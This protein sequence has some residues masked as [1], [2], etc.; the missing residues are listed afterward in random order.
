MDLINPNLPIRIARPSRSLAMAE[1]F[2]TDGVG[3]DVLWRTGPEAEGGHRLLMLGV[4]GASWHLEL[5]DDADALSV[6]PPGPEDLLVIYRGTRLNAT[7]LER[8]EAAGGTRV[9][10]RNPYWD[11]HGQ[12][13]LD[14]DG[15]LLVLSHRTWG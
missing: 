7:E 14:P 6:N 13:I 11:E 15:Y 1:K 9:A 8:L 3:L 12:T 4:P 5:V 10:S 2:W